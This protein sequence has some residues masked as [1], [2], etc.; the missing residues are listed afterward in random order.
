MRSNDSN[1]TIFIEE[2]DMA[3]S[4]QPEVD[5]GLLAELFKDDTVDEIMVNGPQNIYVDRDKLEKVDLS[6]KNTDHLMRTI[7]SILSSL[8]I[9]IDENA[10]I[11][12]ARLSDGSRIHVIIPPLTLTGPALTIRKVSSFVLT[13][14]HLQSFGSFNEK[15]ADFLRACVQAKLNI[16]V[17]GN[18]GS[19]KTTLLNAIASTIPADERIV[20]IEET[21]EYRLPQEHVVALESRP[22]SIQG[23]GAVT[24]QDLVNTSRY[25]RADRI[26]VGELS[27]AEVLDVLRLMD[28]GYNGTMTSIHADSPQDALA[29]LEMLIK[30]N[31]PDLPV[32]YLR[33]LIGS[34]VDLVVQQFRLDDG[35]RKVVRITEV[36]PVR[37]GD[38]ELHDVF[39]FQRDDL[40]SGRVTGDFESHPVSAGLMRRMDARNIVLPPSLLPSPAQGG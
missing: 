1:Y 32:S 24:I 29:N 40:V 21:A 28:K 6:F 13:L 8:G 2:N 3:N 38:Y 33:L 15:M 4:T 27:G 36:L 26:L 12:Q 25:M 10:P 11:V 19:G 35:R 20:T 30:M 37:G 34:A 9:H 17:S 22:T 23:K 7:D 5:F 39:I 31:D 14:D 18:M 16:I